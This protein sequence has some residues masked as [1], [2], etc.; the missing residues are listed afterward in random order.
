MPGIRHYQHHHWPTCKYFFYSFNEQYFWSEYKYEDL[1]KAPQ[2]FG[3]S[4]YIFLLFLF[5]CLILILSL[6]LH[7]QEKGFIIIIIIWVKA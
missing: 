6:H 3:S 1:A 7:F 2:S 5:V 4:Y